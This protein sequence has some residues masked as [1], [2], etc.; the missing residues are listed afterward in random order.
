MFYTFAADA[1]HDYGTI[2]T[3]GYRKLIV[4]DAVQPQMRDNMSH[5]LDL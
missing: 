1:G 4:R 3:K 5:Q 2:E